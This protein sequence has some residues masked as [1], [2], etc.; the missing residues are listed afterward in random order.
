M[1][2]RGFAA[3]NPDVSPQNSGTWSD[4]VFAVARG[5]MVSSVGRL[6]LYA[7]MF[8]ALPDSLTAARCTDLSD[9]QSVDT[10]SVK[11]ITK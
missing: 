10:D 7:V 5:V 6:V 1:H 11:H 8:T 2:T 3:N 9:T 4:T